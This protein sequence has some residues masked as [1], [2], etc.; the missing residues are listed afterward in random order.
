MEWW[1]SL[2]TGLGGATGIILAL[3]GWL[4]KV[5]AARILESDRVK[6]QT[7]MDVILADVRT[8]DKKELLVHEVQFEKEFEVYRELWREALKLGRTGLPFGLLFQG[9]PMPQEER[10]NHVREAYSSLSDT[11]YE[12]RP[13][14]APR[15][16]EAGKSLLTAL[17]KLVQLDSR[18]ARL[19]QST[20]QE[21]NDETVD[22]L[23]TMD[24][25]MEQ[26]IDEISPQINALCDSIRERIWTTSSTGWDRA[27]ASG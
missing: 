23:S 19:E 24:S 1:A 7:Q 25:E 12:N 3:S 20:R 26:I 16:Y 15:V 10:V 9:P 27:I 4:G 22:R 14:Y 17:E 2:L 5:W 18:R 21:R 6:Y 8:K 13:F 11:L